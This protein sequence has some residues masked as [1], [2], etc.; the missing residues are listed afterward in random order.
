MIGFFRADQ[1][2]I[3]Q[4]ECARLEWGQVENA[5]RVS[6]SDVG[7][8]G[9]S[10]RIDVCLDATKTYTLEA[11]GAGG[12]VEERVQMADWQVCERYRDRAA[13]ER[14][15]RDRVHD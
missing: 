7:R 14:W 3:E 13:G 4:G 1:D 15:V 8:V 11:T 12:K 9:S 5:N 6:L 10:G 2:T